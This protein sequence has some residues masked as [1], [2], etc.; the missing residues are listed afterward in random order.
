MV[1]I[2]TIPNSILRKKS[3]PAVWNKKTRD[4]V[5]TLKK[6]LTNDK[7]GVKGVGLAAVQIG[8]PKRVF[9]AYSEKSKKF[10]TFINPEIIW[11]SKRLTSKKDQKY[12]GCLSLPNKWT[13]IKRAKEI[14]VKY[15]TDT[16]QI[17]TRKFSGQMAI[18][19]QHEYD[20]LGGILFVDRVL[21]QKAKLYELKTDEEGKEYL[22]EITQLAN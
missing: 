22:E 14:K 17:Q 16:G 1:K 4:L 3:Q 18:I 21:E 19:I 20:H 10:L 2:L 9:V 8:T 12:E 5:E 13:Q 15:Q 11:L 6:A 7:G